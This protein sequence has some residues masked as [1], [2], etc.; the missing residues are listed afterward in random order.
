MNKN[1]L[2]E[3]KIC[4]DEWIEELN[5]FEGPHD[6][7]YFMVKHNLKPEVMSE[8]I[9]AVEE[10]QAEVAELEDMMMLNDPGNCANAI[11]TNDGFLITI[12]KKK[13]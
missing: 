12:D 7:M 2:Q 11:A 8:L 1:E 6:M 13:L 5:T 4:I 9:A 10:L 3:I